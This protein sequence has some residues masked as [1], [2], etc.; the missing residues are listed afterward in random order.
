MVAANHTSYIDPP[1]VGLSLHPRHVS[2]MAKSELFAPRVMGYL[3]P[4]VGAFP[5]R[6]GTADRQALRHAHALLTSGH[7]VAIFFE[8]TRSSDGRLQPPELGP[9][10]IALRAGVPVLPVAL[11]DAD[12]MLPREGGLHFARVTVVIG[13]PLTFSHLAGQ[14]NDRDAL[15]EVGETIA[16]AVADLLRAHGA[17]DRI[18]PD[19][20]AHA[21]E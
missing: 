1:L 11:I 21:T 3:L 16:H 4:R 19:Y 6:R 5:V 20:L 17:A 10:M 8:G 13:A 7:A 2:F 12:K 14:H 18:P 9:A 15:R